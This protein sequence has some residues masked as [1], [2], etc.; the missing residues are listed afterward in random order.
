MGHGIAINAATAGYH[1][2][3]HDVSP[4]VEAGMSRIKAFLDK[5]VAQNNRKTKR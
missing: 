2:T 5:G 3:L 1:V 4:E